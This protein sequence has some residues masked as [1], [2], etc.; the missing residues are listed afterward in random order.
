[1]LI[2]FDLDVIVHLLLPIGMAGRARAGAID[3]GRWQML[4]KLAE[5]VFKIALGLFDSFG[6]RHLKADAQADAQ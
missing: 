6:M 2:K 3:I 4:F 5:F 1:M